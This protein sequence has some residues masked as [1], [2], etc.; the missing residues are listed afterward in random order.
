MVAVLSENQ[1]TL[2]VSV[3]VDVRLEPSLQEMLAALSETEQ[4]ELRALRRDVARATTKF[5]AFLR[6]PDGANTPVD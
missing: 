5:F 6:D 3:D 2:G 4:E 1:G